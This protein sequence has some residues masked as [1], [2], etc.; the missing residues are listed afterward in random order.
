MMT[1]G[2]GDKTYNIIRD[3]LVLVD[4]GPVTMTLEAEIKREPFTEAAVSGAKKVLES[5]DDLVSFIDV[6]RTPLGRMNCLP[7]N[8]PFVCKQMI[9]SVSSLEEG[10]FTPMAAVAGTLS[11]LAADAMAACGAD[12]AVANNGGDIALYLPESMERTF[13]IGLISDI[14]TGRTT[15]RLEI[16]PSSPI[17]GIA[18]SGLGGRSLTRG[19]ASAVTV[20]A[21]S[22]SMADAAATAIANACFCQDPAIEQCPAEEIDYWTDIPGL[23]VTRSVGR[24]D[25]K[26]VKS[27]LDAGLIRAEELINKG[28]ILGAVLFVQGRMAKLAT[29]DI[30]GLFILSELV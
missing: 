5:F 24:L 22:G 18:T 10:D 26:N 27:A 29:C 25:D 6:I 1:G 2:F 23:T 21:G 17:H 15:H 12:Y 19:I 13:R 28:L 11:D 14:S 30:D 4:F 8:I 20:M 3:G 9:E 7:Q 16:S